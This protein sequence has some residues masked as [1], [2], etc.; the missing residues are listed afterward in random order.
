M[1]SFS[2]T[3]RIERP[4]AEVFDL[5]TDFDDMATRVGGIKKIELLTAGP[6]GE[7]TRFRETREMFGKEATEEMEIT[8]FQ[9][10]ESYTVEAD[11]HGMHYRS[12]FRFEPAGHGT[13]VSC[14][15]EATPTTLTARLLSPLTWMMMKG[16]TKK[17][18]SEDIDDLKQAAE[19]HNR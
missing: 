15:F 17:C 19:Q 9:P 14:T 2:V 16:T 13:D 7:G 11:S 5:F 1:G 8:Q 10:Q 3:R 18:F 6:A 4:R 12:V